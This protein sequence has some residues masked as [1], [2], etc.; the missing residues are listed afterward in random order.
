VE[1]AR[2]PTHPAG[3]LRHGWSR[4]PACDDL[5]DKLVRLAAGMYAS[6]LKEAL[7]P[8]PKVSPGHGPEDV[9]GVGIHAKAEGD[10]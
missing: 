4:R 8:E 3:K 10:R 5:Q 9:A 1:A 6:L 7:E 2:G